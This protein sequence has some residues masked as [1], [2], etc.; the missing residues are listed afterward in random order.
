M[1]VVVRGL[2]CRELIL[3]RVALLAEVAEEGFAGFAGGVGLARGWML[4]FQA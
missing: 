3:A 4:A 1:L 2:V